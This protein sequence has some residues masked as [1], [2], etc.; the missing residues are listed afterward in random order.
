M[1]TWGAVQAGTTLTMSGVETIL[2]L[3]LMMMQAETRRTA[4]KQY[5]KVR[6]IPGCHGDLDYLELKC[7]VA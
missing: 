1:M 3:L 7:N 5:Y 2:R 4:D 6:F